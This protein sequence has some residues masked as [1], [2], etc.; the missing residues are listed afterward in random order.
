ME[1][2]ITNNGKSKIVICVS[3]QQVHLFRPSFFFETGKDKR[4]FLGEVHIK[5][6]RQQ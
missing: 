1:I 3:R 5:I 4:H 6:S 2:V